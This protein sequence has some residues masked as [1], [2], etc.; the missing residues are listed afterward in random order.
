MFRS[1]SPSQP[2]T[3]ERV[4][5]N[6]SQSPEP[7]R[8]EKEDS[9]SN[10][11]VR[12]RELD[13]VAQRAS[14]ERARNRLAFL[15][16]KVA[17]LE[18][19]DQ[20]Q[21]VPNLMNAL[22]KSRE[23]NARLRAAL[24]RIRAYTD[25]DAIDDAQ[26]DQSCQHPQPREDDMDNNT[27]LIHQDREDYEPNA[28]LP[29]VPTT[30]L[31]TLKSVSDVGG[32]TFTSAVEANYVDPKRPAEIFTHCNIPSN[33]FAQQQVEDGQ[34]VADLIA[35]LC[36]TQ[37]TGNSIAFL[38]ILDFNRKAMFLHQEQSSPLSMGF[39]DYVEWYGANARTIVSQRKTIEEQVT[40]YQAP[41]KSLFS[42]WDMVDAKSRTDPMWLSLRPSQQEIQHPP[43]IEFLVWPG[44]RE[45]LVFNHQRYSRAGELG[46]AL[47]AYSHFHWPFP[48]EKI[49]TYDQTND[50]K[51]SELFQ[52]Y[53][54]KIENWSMDKEFFQRFPE[55]KNDIL[56]TFDTPSLSFYS[57][58]PGMGLEM[59][60]CS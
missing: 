51:I 50:W 18:A 10:Q 26:D 8:M 22:I 25:V 48:D 42:G 14:R 46:P 52:S 23:E 56:C 40:Q 34:K 44:L 12:K 30:H 32:E 60:F 7:V 38:E 47:C 5:Q 9:K 21:E 37:N 49:V 16:E 19:L 39:S 4:C 1:T 43:V 58:V 24:R 11:R 28:F 6:E 35:E 59:A 54:F 2:L 33:D 57:P 3:A 20:N 31:D 15:E 41:F 17:K 27:S 29:F 45:R 53:A 36:S 13:R 55:M